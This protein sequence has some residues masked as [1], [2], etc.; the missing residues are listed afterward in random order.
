MLELIL[1]PVIIGIRG[2]SQKFCKEKVFHSPSCVQELNTGILDKYLK[3][4][5]I[6]TMLAIS[7]A[8]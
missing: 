8:I 1:K 7:F 2:R 4:V 3:T 5:R 6:G